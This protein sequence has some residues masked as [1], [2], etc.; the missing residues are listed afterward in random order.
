MAGGVIGI[1]SSLAK[2]KTARGRSRSPYLALHGHGHGHGH[3]HD[4]A[5]QMLGEGPHVYEL[6]AAS[7][8]HGRGDEHNGARPGHGESAGD[9]GDF[10]AD[11]DMI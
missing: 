9:D 5:E 4:M 2:Q 10:D 11:A 1:S 8:K 7:V 3:G 6:S